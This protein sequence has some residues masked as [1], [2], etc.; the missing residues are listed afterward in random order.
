[1]KSKTEIWDF[2]FKSVGFG[3]YDVT[4]TSPTTGK[5]WTK[6]ISDMRIIDA[7]KNED[8]PKRKDLNHLKWLCKN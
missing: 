4:Y 2:E 6:T 8:E 1:M 5:Q 7:T 3:H